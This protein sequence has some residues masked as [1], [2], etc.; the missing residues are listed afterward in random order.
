MLKYDSSQAQGGY[1]ALLTVLIVGAAATAIGLLL[2]TT[3]IDSQRTSLVEQQSKQA[4]S[5]AVACAEEALQIV[6]DTTSYTGNS[7]L[8]LGQ[9]GCTYTVTSTGAST[10]TITTTGTVGS[11]VRKVQVYVTIGSSS[12]S[13]T[14]WQEV[15]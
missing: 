4:R 1:V 9:G 11:V 5:L 2:L 14:S 7:S 8:S 12:I 13:I 6:H 10:R 15:S 3:A